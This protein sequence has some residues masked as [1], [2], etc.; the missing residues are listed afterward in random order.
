MSK[1]NSFNPSIQSIISI[2]YLILIIFGHIY[3]NHFYLSF[4]IYI[5]DYLNPVEYIFPIL[6]VFSVFIFVGIAFF[7]WIFTQVILRAVYE[8]NNKEK[9]DIDREITIKKKY[10]DNKIIKKIALLLEIGSFILYPSALIISFLVNEQW[11]SIIIISCLVFLF[12]SMLFVTQIQKF[13]LTTLPKIYGIYAMG[14]IFFVGTVF[15]L[16][17][18]NN[19]KIK[20][21]KEGKNQFAPNQK[22]EYR[23]KNIKIIT[24]DTIHFLGQSKDFIF[25]YDSKNK[26][27]KIINKNSDNILLIKNK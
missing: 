11:I 18:I 3:L 22:V 4:N 7:I 15:L 21:I 14:I 8:H 25:F 9:I 20:E 27:S 1:K 2:G 12:F 6:P 10:V 16:F 13:S 17:T 23:T 26:V 19:S 24:N 5:S